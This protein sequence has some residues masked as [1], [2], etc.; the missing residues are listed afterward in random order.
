MVL[1][2][3]YEL[4]DRIAVG[5]MGE[6]WQALDRRLGRTVAVKVLRPELTGDELFLARLR[7]EA[8]NT[9]GLQHPNLARLLDHG[10]E[11]GSGY[12]VMELVCGETLADRLRCAGTVPAEDLVPILVQACRGLHAAH[13]AGIVHR[14]V[15]PANVIITGDGEVKLTD[16]GISLAANQAPMTSAGM[17]MGTA[18]YLPPEQ[19]TGHPATAVG[20]VYALGV[21]AYECLVGERPFTGRTQVDV[22]VAHVNQPVPALPDAVPPGLAAV[23]TRMLEKHPADRPASALAC[24]REL[25]N[26]LAGTEQ[27]FTPEHQPADELESAGESQ[28]AGTS[29]PALVTTT[30]R[31]AAPGRRHLATRPTPRLTGSVIERT[32][33]VV[34]H[35]ALPTTT[36]RHS[37][38]RRRTPASVRTSVAGART[39]ARVRPAR[40]VRAHVGPSTTAVALQRARESVTGWR[41]P[42]WRELSADRVWLVSMA[43]VLTVLLVLTAVLAGAGLGNLDSAARSASPP[44]PPAHSSPMIPSTVRT[45]SG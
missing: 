9:A 12:L 21:L 41:V 37:S 32:G 27:E 3:R 2:S 28:A 33:S 29:R 11:R 16:F 4:T 6:V 30:R 13:T 23:V 44:P 42:T 43:V 36:S 1:G 40:P 20:D 8:R 15:K 39:P 24:A 14:D 5:G 10:E 17:V 25:E 38:G 31:S 18:H 35:L 45:S 7:T 22:A 26:S 19:A 34:Q